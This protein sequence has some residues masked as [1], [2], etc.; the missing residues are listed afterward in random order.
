[1]TAVTVAPV[2]TVE[3]VVDLTVELL[4]ELLHED[5]STLAAEL[6]AKGERM[7]IDS[8]D[9]FDILQGFRTRT[10]ITLPV[11]SLKRNTLRSVRTFAEFVIDKAT[12]P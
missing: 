8:L 7:P 6:A 12:H 5:P 11:R 10:G 4:A 1:M 3:D 2:K 9:M